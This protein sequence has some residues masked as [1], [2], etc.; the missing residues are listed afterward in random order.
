MLATKLFPLLTKPEV[1]ELILLSGKPPCAV[2]NG[3]YRRLRAQVLQ[4]EDILAVIMAAHGQEH[5]ERLADGAQWDFVAPGIGKVS[6]TARYDGPNLRLTLRLAGLS[7]QNM[8]AGLP[9][10]DVEPRSPVARQP[11]VRDV[12]SRAE[13]EQE[14]RARSQDSGSS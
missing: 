8:P 10:A 11:K 3:S 9:R 14:P 5:A 12:Q 6:A 13:R 4:D 7:V 1:Q 2:V